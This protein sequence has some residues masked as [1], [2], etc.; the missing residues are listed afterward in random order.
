[1]LILDK[2]IISLAG[3]IRSLPGWAPLTLQGFAG[4]AGEG[5]HIASALIHS[6]DDSLDIFLRLL[7]AQL[8]HFRGIVAH[9]GFMWFKENG[10]PGVMMLT[11]LTSVTNENDPVLREK[12]LRAYAEEVRAE[13]ERSPA[14]TKSSPARSGVSPSTTRPPAVIHLP[15][16]SKS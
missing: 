9:P 12:K 11:Y 10:E 6:G 3:K 15:D 5:A 4:K 14:S 13:F 1:V 7:L 2:G 16:Q 8:I